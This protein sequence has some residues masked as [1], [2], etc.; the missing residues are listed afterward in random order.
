MLWYVAILLLGIK[1]MQQQYRVWV[2]RCNALNEVFQKLSGHTHSLPQIL[3]FFYWYLNAVSGAT[4]SWRVKPTLQMRN[5]KSGSWKL[6]YLKL[7]SSGDV[8]S[9]K[10]LAPWK[11]GHV[12]K[13]CEQCDFKRGYLL[14]LLAIVL[15]NLSM[16]MADPHR[17]CKC[18]LMNKTSQWY[19]N[20]FTS[21]IFRQ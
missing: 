11:R 19:V 13:Q 3:N 16:K 1:V 7:K 20:V 17:L 10:R 4:L 18:H 8:H 5:I 2:V 9:G 12:R 14:L 6:K 21:F 15:W